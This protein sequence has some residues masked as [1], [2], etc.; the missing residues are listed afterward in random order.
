MQTLPIS[1]IQPSQ[2]YLNAVKLDHI[3]ANL[4]PRSPEPLPVRRLGG[5][6]VLTDGHHRLY[7]A[8]RAGLAEVPVYWDP[9]PLDWEAYAICVE[10]C[11]AQGIQTVAD[12][13]HAIVAPPEYERLWLD[14]CR[15]MQ[16]ALERG[17]VP[18]PPGS[19]AG[20]RLRRFRGEADFPAMVAV[21][22]ASRWADGIEYVTTLEDMPR[23]LQDLGHCEPERDLI[24]AE[25]GPD[26]E[27]AGWGATEWF[28]EDQGPCA[29]YQTFYMAPAWRGQGIERALLAALERRALAK[30]AALPE[31]T[32]PH[33]L[34]GEAYSTQPALEAL[35]RE[36][37]YRPVRTFYAMVRSHLDNLPDLPLPLGLEVRPAQPEHYRL[38]W[39]AMEEAFQD[40]W[41]HARLEEDH[42]Q[43]WLAGRKFNPRLWQIAWD[44]DQIAGIVLVEID[45]EQ[46]RQHNQLRGQTEPIC[47]L[48]PWRRRGLASALLVRALQGLKAAGMQEAALGVDAEGESGAL[49]LYER[50]GFQ[51]VK[52]EVI[53]EKQCSLQHHLPNRL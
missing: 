25:A 37:G 13:G 53:Y 22:N 36:S 49:Q 50:V 43:A 33:V 23:I 9:D 21:R 24:L 47:V 41:G 48:R 5:R 11:L 51:T 46:N 15:V 26:G 30:I 18:L 45:A 52:R 19:P 38:I 44:G 10:W 2:L 42:Y 20:L 31:T 6:I 17:E 27:L 8:Q 16:A 35:L 29:H 34:R 12:L 39:D 28:E 32:P 3:Q 14:R 4:D 1:T 7:A 40:H